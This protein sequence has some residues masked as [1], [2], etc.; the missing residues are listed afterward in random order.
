MVS[1]MSSSLL[2][3]V[4]VVVQ[5]VFNELACTPPNP[6]PDKWRYNTE[7]LYILRLGPLILRIHQL[8][9]RLCAVLEVLFY[10]KS[11]PQL[12][13]T[14]SPYTHFLSLSTQATIHTTPLFVAGVIAVVIGATIRLICFHVLGEFFTFD[15][16]VHPKH[17]LITTGPYCIVR[18]PAYTG[19]LSIIAG[20]A[21]SHLSPGSWLW[22]CGPLHIVPASGAVIATLWWTWT[23]WIGLNRVEAED[24]QMRALFP[25]E[26]DAYAARVTKWFIPGVV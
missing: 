26:W 20:L 24:R 16:T 8:I 25:D 10:L 1:L 9:V 14:L 18:H 17:R 15:L 6:T 5:T 4:L 3:V 11:L 12:A 21:A 22:E 2:R 7:T 13:A 23:L 19:S